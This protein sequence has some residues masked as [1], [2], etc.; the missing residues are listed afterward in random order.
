MNDRSG[1]TE[2]NNELSDTEAPHPEVSRDNDFE[3]ELARYTSHM[4][5]RKKLVDAELEMAGRFTNASLT[6]AGGALALT[7]TYV[8]KLHPHPIGSAL[9]WLGV[10]WFFLAMSL[11]ASLVALLFSLN[12]THV[13]IQHSD[14]LYNC[15]LRERTTTFAAPANQ[16]SAWTHYCNYLSVGGFLFGIIAFFVFVSQSPP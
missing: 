7:I 2:S 1:D 8:E 6:L 15:W 13:A 10:T 12:A 5:H 4:E 3:N 11:T 14:K 9:S 16:F